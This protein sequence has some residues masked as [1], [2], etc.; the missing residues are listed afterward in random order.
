MT[1]DVAGPDR[2]D[3]VLHAP[4]A[5]LPDGERPATLTVTQAVIM[6]VGPLDRSVDGREVVEL[7][8]DEVL[9]PGLV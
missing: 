7:R 4:R 1:A 6:Q 9:L 8:D 5:V 2:P 3:L